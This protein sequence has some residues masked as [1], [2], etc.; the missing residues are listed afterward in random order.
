MVLGKR[1]GQALELSLAG[2]S[3]RLVGWLFP[4]PQ[5]DGDDRGPDVMQD[6]LLL[7]AKLEDFAPVDRG[8]ELYGY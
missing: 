5:N 3:A 1:S 6:S 2:A 7:V 8:C 4:K